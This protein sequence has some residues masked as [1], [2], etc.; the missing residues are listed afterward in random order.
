MFSKL[1]WFSL[2]LLFC[3]M[4]QNS[5]ALEK[6]QQVI[7]EIKLLIDVSGSMKSNDPNNLRIPATQ[8]LVNLLPEGSKAGIWLFAENTKVLME[9]AVVDKKWKAKALSNLKKIHSLGLYTNIEDAINVSA[10]D[11]F[12]AKPQQNRNLILLTDGMVDV[13]EDIMQS[14]ESRERV[15]ADQ[16]PLLQQAGVKVQT[17]AL[18]DNADAELLSKLAF[19]TNGWSET[20]LTADRLQK[21][22]FKIFKKAVQQD[23]VPIT[24]NAFSVDASIK[25]FSVLIFKNTGAQASQLVSPGNRKISQINH[26]ENVIW[27]DEK[28]YDLVT[29]KKPEA[30]DWQ[31]EAEIDPDNQVMI[32]TDLKLHLDGVSNYIVE[33]EVIEIIAHFT[34]QQSLII[35]QDFLQ[36]IDVS[37]VHED[38]QGKKSQ[39]AMLPVIDKLGFFSKTIEG[40]LAVGKHQLNIVADGKTFQRME[41]QTI[42]VI[43]SLVVTEVIVDKKQRFVTIKLLPDAAVINTEMMTAQ[44]VISQQGKESETR[45]LDKQGDYWVLTVDVTEL[46]KNKIINFSIMANTIEG[47]VISPQLKPVLINEAL[48]KKK[49]T[50]DNTQPVNKQVID[51][52]I[53]DM[54]ESEQIDES[55]KSER[56]Q[57]EDV[58]WITTSVTVVVVNII[59]LVGGFF[60]YKMLRKKTIEKQTQL[61]EQFE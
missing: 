56:E 15:M 39:W 58:N 43:E 44:A 48:F 47:D 23:T 14:A 32:V 2:T 49:K 51:E 52:D 18:S 17:I 1:R 8:L 11:W 50:P 7:D 13:S 45:V 59:L 5:D 40:G 60:L 4:I 34:D 3:L 36:L 53:D 20:T 6:K 16:L 25:E 35:R 10:Q 37:L 9:M 19:D 12:N 22:F 29:I 54:L 30:G 46:S 21:V 33:G 61:L 42:E 28:N 26:K 31:I 24:G 41:L 27:L 57:K 38:E 55:K